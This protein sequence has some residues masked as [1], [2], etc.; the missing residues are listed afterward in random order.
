MRVLSVVGTRP[1]AIKMGPVIRELSRREGI[2]SRV[3][4]TAQH[5]EMLDQALDL[6][7]VVPDIDLDLMRSDQ[8]PTDVAVAV[9]TGLQR[10]LARESFDWVVVQGDT[11]T[12]AAAAWAAYHAHVRVAHVEAGLR[13]GDKWQ[14]YPEEINRRIVSVIADLHLAPTQGACRHLL[15]EGVD[16]SRIV[17]TGN[18]VVD[19][20]R[21]VSDLPCDL[22]AGPL[23]DLDWDKRVLL[24]TAHRR[25]NH[26]APLRR[27]C[28]ALRE[29]AITYRDD[30]LVVYPVH[31]SPHVAGPV[32]ELLSDVPGVRLLPPLGYLEFVQLLGRSYLVLTDSGGVQEE[33]PG[34]GKP[35]LVL[36]ETTERPE[37]VAAGMAKL[38]GTD[39]ARL[40][41]EVRHL[42][43]DKRA[44]DAMAQAVNPYGDGH[45]A[46]R[47]VDAL[48]AFDR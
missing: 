30:V 26:G 12:A 22:S 24:V 17:L 21:W 45:A 28:M 4:A 18:P 3:C 6:L 44:Y 15:V 25:E 2:V 33:A 32:H 5:R 36:R 20:L 14:P 7:G 9:L 47:I 43:T 19:A 42:L 29:I 11:T 40:V 27:I 13:S 16:E 35:V 37:A 41:S 48:E 8:T 31:P 46:R 34:L 1:E 39:Q 38:V 23:A 10:L